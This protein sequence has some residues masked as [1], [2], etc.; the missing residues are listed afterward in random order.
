[1]IVNPWNEKALVED[2]EEGSEAYIERYLG[3]EYGYNE[4]DRD[5]R[6]ELIRIDLFQVQEAYE[7]GYAE[8][9]RIFDA[10]LDKLYGQVIELFKRATNDEL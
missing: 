5:K 7:D 2:C 6:K 1:M 9:E 10:K 4:W 3:E 8:A